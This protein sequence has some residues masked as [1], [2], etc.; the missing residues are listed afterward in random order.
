MRVMHLFN[1]HKMVCGWAMS[2]NYSYFKDLFKRI[3]G[4]CFLVFRNLV[5]KSLVLYKSFGGN[6]TK[7]LIGKVKFN[8]PAND[9]K[10]LA[11]TFNFF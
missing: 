2:S 1:S 5:K 6:L 9:C 4:I 3:K 7:H 11:V 10:W 8:T